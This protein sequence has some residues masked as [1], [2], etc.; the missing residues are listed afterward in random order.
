MVGDDGG[1]TVLSFDE[2]GVLERADEGSLPMPS[3]AGVS[4]WLVLD[5]TSSRKHPAHSP[6][7]P[8]GIPWGQ[9]PRNAQSH[10]SG[11]H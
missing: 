3:S 7:H 10:L 9:R 1:T 2:D 4:D 11:C 6:Q 5:L 8:Q